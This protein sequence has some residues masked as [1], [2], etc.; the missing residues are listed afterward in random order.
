MSSTAM[1]RS[2]GILGVHAGEDVNAE[3]VVTEYLRCVVGDADLGVPTRVV[4]QIA[5]TRALDGMQSAEWDGYSAQW[6]YHPDNGMNL[7]IWA[8]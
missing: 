2:S 5:S 3:A 1:Q 8:S 7:T 6:N 4:D